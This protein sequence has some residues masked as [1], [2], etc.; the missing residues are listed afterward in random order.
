MRN[1]GPE[2]VVHVVAAIVTDAQGRI[3]IT[4]RPDGAHQGGKW[5]FPGGKVVAGE[6]ALDALKRELHEELG[7]EIQSAHP[8]LRLNHIYPERSITLDSWRVT[9]YR[10][11]PLGREGQPLRW[12]AAEQLFVADFPAADRPI[13]RRLQ[14]PALYLISDFQRYGRDVFITK[15]KRAMQAG[16]RL[17]QLREP[18]MAEQDYDRLARD[19]L[20][21]CRRRGAKLLLNATPDRALR[22]G[23]DGV[24][25]NSAHLM[26]STSRPLDDR[27]WVAASCHNER[28]LAHAQDLGV[29]FVVLGP[30]KATPSHARAQPMGWKTFRQ[31]CDS[32]W[33]PVFALGGMG[34]DDFARARAAGAQGVA[35]ISGMWDREDIETAVRAVA[36]TIDAIEEKTRV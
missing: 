29:D 4:R 8:F 24:H 34:I 18:G 6:G 21:L 23:A 2:D 13:L 26:Q 1:T 20:A 12:M 35:M 22:C 36:G 5:E 9:A 30:V 17:F 32:S 28:E 14:L 7:I 27:Y 10:G 31:Y 33:L 15:L 3:L 16:A 19:V 11:E 25:L